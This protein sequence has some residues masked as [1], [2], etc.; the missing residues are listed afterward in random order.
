MSKKIL[1]NEDARKALKRGVDKV[2]NAVKITIG[3]RGRNVV[4]DRGYGAPTITNDGVTIAKEITLKDKFENMGAEIAKEVAQ[5]TNDVAGDGTTTSV[6]LT[7]MIFAEGLRQTGF[8]ANA[9]AIRGGIEKATELVVKTL[10]EIAKP[11]KDKGE[12]RQVAAISS[13]NEEVGQIIADTIDKVGK[14]GVVTVEEAQTIGVDSEVVEGLEFDKGFV[15]PYM[16]TNAE[17]M[18]AEYHDPAILVTDKKISGIKEILPLLEKLATTGKKDLVIIAED[19]EGEALT[20]FVLNKLRGTFNVLAIKAPGYGDRKK[21]LLGDI[22]VTIGAKVVSE[23]LG[24][25]LENAEL[26]VLGHA[27]RVVAN[28]DKTT[29]V[30]GKGKKPDIEARLVSLKKQKE[31]LDSKYDV[32]KLDERIAKLSGGVAV[33]RVGAATETEMKYL[34]LKIEDAVNATKAAIAEGI[35]A[36]GGVALIRAAEKAGE[37]LKREKTKKEILTKEFEVGFNIVL[38]ALE[39]PLRQIAVNAGKDDGSVIVEKIRTGKGNIGYD[40][41]KDEMVAD[42]LVAGIID[43]VKVTRSGLENAASA[44]A[45]LLTTEAAIADEPEKNPPVGGPMPGGMGGGEMEY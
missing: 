20:T 11:I 14:D 4:F 45:I 33:I 7:Q 41:L 1:Y 32:E 17:R 15:S 36:G 38:K 2:A 5:K 27:R 9:M 24:I 43:P 13:E 12:I 31:A 16:I 21:D 3:P 35:V 42:M 40:A 22:A 25:K 6:I 28:K 10:K 26:N 8:G 44:A 37:W 18:E 34:K 39:A 19:I 30:G 23:E 29:I